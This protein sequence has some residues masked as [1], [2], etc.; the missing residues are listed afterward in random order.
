MQVLQNKQTELET[1]LDSVTR[2]KRQIEAERTNLSDELNKINNET[3]ERQQA[4]D[5]LHKNL[6]D[7]NSGTK[8]L[9]DKIKDL[10]GQKVKLEAKAKTLDD[11][12]K[13]KKQA[14]DSEVQK[15]I[16]LERVKSGL[17]DGIKDLNYKLQTMA[18]DKSSL[19]QKKKMKQKKKNYPIWK[20]NLKKISRS[21]I[22][23]K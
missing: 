6:G 21:T 20:K 14:F 22:R 17:E 11:D 19:D 12:F 8:E 3:Q 10:T 2:D 4:I 5:D 9:T 7:S 16:D 23:I 1:S 13:E 18:K 15:G